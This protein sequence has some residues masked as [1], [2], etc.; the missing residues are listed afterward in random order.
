[1]CK[2]TTPSVSHI[3]IT[4][5]ISSLIFMTHIVPCSFFF[6]LNDPEPPNISPLPLPHPLPISPSYRELN[7]AGSMHLQARRCREVT[8]TQALISSLPLVYRRWCVLKLYIAIIALNCSQAQ[9]LD[10]KSTRLNSSHQIIS[11]AVFCL[12]KK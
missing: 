8:P 3:F 2:R 1:M 7:T 10:R 11:Y 4:D 9:A 5:N 12:K 6:F